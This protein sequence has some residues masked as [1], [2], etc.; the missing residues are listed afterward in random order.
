MLLLVVAGCWL[1]VGGWGWWVVVVGVRGGGVV[2]WFIGL[3]VS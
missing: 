3:L 1:V 2:C